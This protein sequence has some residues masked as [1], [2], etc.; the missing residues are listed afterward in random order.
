M[1]NRIFGCDDCLGVCP[2]NRFAEPASHADY[3]PRPGLDYP[4]YADLLA[5][6]EESFRVRFRR[7]PIKRTGRTRMRRN[8][9]VALGHWHS[10]K[11]LRL[12][13]GL[14]RDADPLV[15]EHAA[16]AWNRLMEHNEKK[17]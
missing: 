16:W 2:W 12:L 14:R 1:G 10:K 7:S 11:A 6:D 4:D 15:R 8:M 9:A 3:H 5:L 13:E 17:D